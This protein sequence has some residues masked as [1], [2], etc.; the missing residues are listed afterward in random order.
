MYYLAVKFVLTYGSQNGLLHLENG[1]SVLQRNEAMRAG[2][3]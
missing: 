1:D 3:T 2:N